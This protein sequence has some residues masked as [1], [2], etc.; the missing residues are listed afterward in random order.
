[1]IDLAKSLEEQ[2]TGQR[3]ETDHGPMAKTLSD[4]VRY[5]EVIRSARPRVV[6]ETGTWTGASAH[7]FGSQMVAA[8]AVDPLVVTIDLQPAADLPVFTSTH[9]GYNICPL[10]GHSTQDPKIHELLR[11]VSVLEAPTM[12][13]LDSDHQAEHVR[14]E[15][16]LY[17]PFVTP[18]QYL[19]VEDTI[20]RHLPSW[21]GDGTPADALDHW[22]PANPEFVPDENLEDSLPDTQHPGGWLRR[23]A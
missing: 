8:G 22:L 7:W 4:L 21:T 12:V 17:A 9:G 3:R 16:A 19:V 11:A 10:Y 20:I 23:T 2:R 13:V 6:I 14:E 1:M 18:G 15:L 5:R